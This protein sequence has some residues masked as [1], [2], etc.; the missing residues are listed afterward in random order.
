MCQSIMRPHCE[1]MAKRIEV[2]FGVD[3]CSLRHTMLH[4]GP[5]HAMRLA[6]AVSLLSVKAEDEGN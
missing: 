6:P 5:A 3:S 2:L 1:K 4:G